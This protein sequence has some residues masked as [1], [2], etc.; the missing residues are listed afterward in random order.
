MNTKG[1]IVLPL[2][3]RETNFSF[4]ETW[5]VIKVKESIILFI[6]SVEHIWDQAIGESSSIY[7]NKSLRKISWKIANTPTRRRTQ[8]SNLK[9]YIYKS[10]ASWPR[11]W[12]KKWLKSCRFFY[13]KRSG[14]GKE[15]RSRLRDN[16]RD[17]SLNWAAFC[18]PRAC[19]R[20]V[21][22]LAL[23]K[24]RLMVSVWRASEGET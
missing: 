8:K 11:R 10:L 5:V 4:H 15:R 1:F 22:E 16:Y 3:L 14:G 17:T 9:P 20:P 6:P 13:F 19:F 23:L 24:G 21:A 7:K 12:G 2:L 18:A